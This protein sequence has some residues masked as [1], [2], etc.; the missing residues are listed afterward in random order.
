MHDHHTTLFG[1]SVHL[2]PVLFPDA[3][4]LLD[5][6]G[7]ANAL[8]VGRTLSIGHQLV[9][10]NAVLI[11]QR[12]RQPFEHHHAAALGAGVA[13]GISGERL[14]PAVRGEHPA[15]LVE[16]EAVKSPALIVIGEVT[17]RED[18]ALAA[19]AQEAAQ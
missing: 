15:D 18:V 12:I 10:V 13:V 1:A 11:G 2:N 6:F 19:L 3:F 9:R 14:D 5:R 17:A 7:Q 8:A 16:A 4:A